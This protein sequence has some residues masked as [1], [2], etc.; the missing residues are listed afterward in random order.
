[1]NTDE[2]EQQ[3]QIQTQKEKIMNLRSVYSKVQQTQRNQQQ[4]QQQK[5]Q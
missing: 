3:K 2:R 5:Q 1:M 4:Q